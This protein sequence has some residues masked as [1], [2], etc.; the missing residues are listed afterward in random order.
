ML[1]SCREVNRREAGGKASPNA[2]SEG[3]VVKSGALAGTKTDTH[4]HTSLSS[5]S[6]KGKEKGKKRIQCCISS[7][8]RHAEHYQTS[9]TTRECSK[10]GNRQEVIWKTWLAR[11]RFR[12]YF[13]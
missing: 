6:Y 11:F 7:F 13:R 10:R 12:V 1:V 8:T 9:C 2:S 5:L 4:T 3:E